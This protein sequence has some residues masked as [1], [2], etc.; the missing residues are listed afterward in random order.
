MA[1]FLDGAQGVS[2]GQL[3]VD[4]LRAG[5]DTHDG[6]AAPVLYFRAW[7]A[8]FDLGISHDAELSVRYREDRAVYQY[9]LVAVRASGDQQNWK[10]LTPSFI[11]AIRRQL[12]MWR[13]IPDSDRHA[14]E[15]KGQV[16][17]DVQNHEASV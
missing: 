17:F 8:P 12:L 15:K 9:H 5:V 14:Y 16:L 13:V 1:E 3:A 4:H 6:H 7:L 11:L 2:V 10:R